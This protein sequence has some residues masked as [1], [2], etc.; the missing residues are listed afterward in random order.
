MLTHISSHDASHLP[1]MQTLDRF[2]HAAQ[3]NLVCSTLRWTV[4]MVCRLL[5]RARH[6]SNN[7]IRPSRPHA[8]ARLFNGVATIISTNRFRSHQRRRYS[9]PSVAFA[10]FP[11]VM[12]TL[13]DMNR[14]SACCVEAAVK[15][16]VQLRMRLWTAMAL[17]EQMRYRYRRL[18]SLNVNLSRW[19]SCPRHSIIMSGNA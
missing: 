9:R 12:S 13:R 8:G 14:A 18:R 15:I 19:Q 7:I 2:L 11:M 1:S 3:H 4:G 16:D 5:T 6:S 17:E 10:R